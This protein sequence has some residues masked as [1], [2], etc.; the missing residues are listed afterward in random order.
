VNRLTVWLKGNSLVVLAL[1]LYAWATIAD[2]GRALEAIGS[3]ARTFLATLPIIAAVF[4]SIGLLN[5]WVDKKKV[6]A[7]LGERAGLAAMVMASLAG[8][9]IVGPVYVIFPLMKV[10]R[11]HGARWAV[12]GTVLTAWAVKIPMVPMEIG[13]LGIRFSLARIL[14]VVVAA[15]PIGLLLEAVMNAGDRRSASR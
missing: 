12:I 10:L 15:I 11:E 4:A 2:P 8:T 9:I 7:A 6:A 5:V 1:V 13:M 3:G 14:L